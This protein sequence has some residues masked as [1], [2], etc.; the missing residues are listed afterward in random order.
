MTVTGNDVD[1]IVEAVV[2]DVWVN[3]E[4]RVVIVVL[5]KM[6]VSVMGKVVVLTVEFMIV[7]YEVCVVVAGT[8]GGGNGN[9]NGGGSPGNPPGPFC[10]S[11]N[12]IHCQRGSRLRLRP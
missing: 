7:M 9:E 10:L 6:E 1:I 3:D 12:D 5:V 2:V 11:D 8:P 4:D